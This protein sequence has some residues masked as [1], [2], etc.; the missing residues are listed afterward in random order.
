MK[1]PAPTV[2]IIALI[3]VGASIGTIR[4]LSRA[5]Q[6]SPPGRRPPRWVT[7]AADSAL[8]DARILDAAV[9]DL[10]TNPELAHAREFYGGRHIK[11]VAYEGFPTGYKPSVAGFVFEPLTRKPTGNSSP[12]Q[13]VIGLSGYWIDRAPTTN[14][15]ASF[16]FSPLSK[17]LALT[18]WNAGGGTIGSGWVSYEVERSGEAWKLRYSGYEDP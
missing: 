11:T 6:S 13:L 18:V 12:K 14:E 5:Q 3:L 4:L 16:F 17:G 15:F 2:L 10:L 9:A 1:Y 7:I 8:R